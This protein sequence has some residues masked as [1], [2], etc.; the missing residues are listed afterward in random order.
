MFFP[1]HQKQYKP[2]TK[3]GKYSGINNTVNSVPLDP[4]KSYDVRS[5][6]QTNIVFSNHVLKKDKNDDKKDKNDDKQPDK[7]DVVNQENNKEDTNLLIPPGLEKKYC[8]VRVNDKNNNIKII[9]PNSEV[10]NKKNIKLLDKPIEVRKYEDHFY[11]NDFGI[12]FV[13]MVDNIVGII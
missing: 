13:K 9:N 10:K 11:E 6:D 5:N 1:V 4:K 8:D 3:Y 2:Y 12:N 7:K